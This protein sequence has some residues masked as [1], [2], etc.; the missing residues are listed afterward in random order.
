MQK[1]V[2]MKLVVPCCHWTPKIQDYSQKCMKEETKDYRLGPHLNGIACRNN[3]KKNQSERHQDQRGRP[4]PR[5]NVYVQS[6]SSIPGPLLGLVLQW[7]ET[8]R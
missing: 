8:K 1:E 2:D 5:N 4:T 3:I 6:G 7:H